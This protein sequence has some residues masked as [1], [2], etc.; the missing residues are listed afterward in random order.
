M[1]FLRRRQWPPIQVAGL[2]VRHGRGA[3]QFRNTRPDPADRRRRNRWCRRSGSIQR[4]V[5]L[6]CL[7]CALLTGHCGLPNNP[8]FLITVFHLAFSAATKLVNS[9]AVIGCA[10]N[11]SR[12]NRSCT[13]GDATAAT[14]ALFNL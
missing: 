12:R 7:D 10:R 9:C 1:E 3:E 6:P 5:V 2:S 13:S 11:P 8:A 4:A 14:V